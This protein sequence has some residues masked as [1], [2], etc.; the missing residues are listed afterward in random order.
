MARLHNLVHVK[1]HPVFRLS[2]IKNKTKNTG[3]SQNVKETMTF[4]INVTYKISWFLPVNGVKNVS[5]L[6]L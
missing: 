2:Y 5:T 1:T 3:A 4:S 6:H